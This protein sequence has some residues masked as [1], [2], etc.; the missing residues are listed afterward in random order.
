MNQEKVS[1]NQVQVS[2]EPD[3]PRGKFARGNIDKLDDENRKVHV[4]YCEIETMK[5]SKCS[6]FPTNLN[7]TIGQQRGTY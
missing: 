2:G 4:P 1:Q 3:S 5:R 7:P 6:R